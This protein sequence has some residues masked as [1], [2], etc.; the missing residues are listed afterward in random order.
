MIRKKRK[1]KGESTIIS[2]KNKLCIKKEKSKF[3]V[4]DILTPSSCPKLLTKK[5]RRSLNAFTMVETASPPA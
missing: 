3:L 2:I 5:S 1:R 4:P